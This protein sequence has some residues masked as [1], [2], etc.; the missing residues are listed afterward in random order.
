MLILHLPGHT[1]PG[2]V[3]RHSRAARRLRV[4]VPGLRGNPVLARR[5]ERELASRSKGVETAQA[6]PQSGRLLIRYRPGASLLDA[7]RTP[8][9]PA[10][11]RRAAAPRRRRGREAAGGAETAA[12]ALRVEEVLERLGA[13]RQGLGEAEAR[14]RL[15]ELG[16]NAVDG[17]PQRAPL[18]VLLGQVQNLPA[19]LLLGSSALSALARDFGGSAAILGA[20]V[21]DAAIGYRIERKNEDLLASWQRLEAG[22]A[23]VLRA[24]RIGAVAAADL[25]PGDIVLCR[26]GDTVPADARVIDAHRLSCDESMLTGESEPRPKSAAP[27]SPIAPLAERASMLFSGTRVA[28][29]H[30]RAVVTATAERTEAARIRGLVERENAPETPFER[31]LRR[32][33]RSLTL[34]GATAGGVALSLGVLRG[35]GL[36][37]TLGQA[38][39]LG[40]AAI[41]EGLPIVASSA[42]V[43]SMQRMREKGMIVRRLVSA[44]TLGGVTVV[45]ADKT[46]TL[47]QNDMR[48]EVLDLGFG[49]LSAAELPADPEKLFDDPVSLALAAAVLNSD[50][51]AEGDAGVLSLDGSSTERALVLAA[52]RA[53]IDRDALRRAFPRRLLR[54]RDGGTHYVVS[55][56]D[57]PGGGALAFVKGAPEQVVALSARDLAGPL[58]GARRR[59]LLARNDELAARGLRVLALAWRRLAAGEAVDLDGN[60]TLIGLAGLRDPLRPDAVQAVRQAARAGIRTVILTGDQRATAEAI[61]REVG[62]AGETVDGSE[63]AKLLRGDGPELQARLREAAVF[64]RV[65]PADKAALVRALRE[66]GEIVAMAGDGINDA[67]ALKAADVG[68]AVGCG[69]SDVSREAA[70]IVLASEELGAVLAAVAEGRIVQENLRRAVRFLV[71]TN[72]AEIVLALGATAFARTHPFTALRLLWLNLL[73]DALPALALALEPGRGDE[74]ERPPQPPSA[75][76]VSA[77]DWATAVRHAGVL[78][79]IGAAGFALAGGLGAFNALTGAVLGYSL[80]CRAR[81]GPPDARFLRMLGGS[82]ALHGASLVLPPLRSA[83]ALPRLASLGELAAFGA[84]FAAPSLVFRGAPELVIV[85]RGVECNQEDAR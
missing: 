16:A 18:A 12:H 81:G 25:V 83:L 40:V 82:V 15:R 34:A 32:L 19:A 75:P 33:G 24:G 61:A 10:T 38:V 55:L 45:C 71:T 79:G 54:E 20:V 11:R 66:A 72:L 85:R 17:A 39:A 56:H 76:F 9:G 6:D 84:G 65:S 1:E 13:T 7:L 44:E 59:R 31:R 51:D 36:G 14:R 29:G 50:V 30:G 27:V 53:G 22:E 37:P 21:L 67:P 52:H 43:Q 28:S 4:D 57:A 23:R 58:D 77:S 60:Y 42:L 26:S 63:L 8:E 62:L 68:I 48:L 69:A 74:L 80:A 46:G 78:A 47:T 41:P 2:R 3:T 49:E 73:S 5:L 35:R 64:A 70:D